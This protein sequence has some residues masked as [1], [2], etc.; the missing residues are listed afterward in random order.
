MSQAT[1]SFEQCIQLLSPFRRHGGI[2]SE[3]FEIR[4][5][6]QEVVHVS[7]IYFYDI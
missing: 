6:V 7:G 1:R 4:G 2:K 3:A 5:I